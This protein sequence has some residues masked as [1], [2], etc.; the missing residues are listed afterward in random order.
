MR[1]KIFFLSNLSDFNPNLILKDT[2]VK[3]PCNASLENM[4]KLF[5]EYFKS[6]Q[7]KISIYE[8][9]MFKISHLLSLGSMVQKGKFSAAAILVLVRTLKNVDFPTLGNPKYRQ[10]NH[11]VAIREF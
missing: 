2:T 5:D 8:D 4:S 10:I 3:R 1:R 7:A 11:I 6:Q 9:I